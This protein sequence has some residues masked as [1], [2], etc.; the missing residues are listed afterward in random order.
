[1]VNIVFDRD[2]KDERKA[3]HSDVGGGGEPIPVVGKLVAAAITSRKL[4]DD[5]H[6][7]DFDRGPT[8]A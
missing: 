3:E 6:V 4:V 5:G 2:E 8:K 1:M 7:R